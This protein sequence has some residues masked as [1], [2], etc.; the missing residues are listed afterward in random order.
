MNSKRTKQKPTT[1]VTLEELF[2][3]LNFYAEKEN[4]LAT[5]YTIECGHKH[6]WASISQDKGLKARKIKEIS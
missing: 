5:N 6:T 4:Y 2:E 1:S 3:T